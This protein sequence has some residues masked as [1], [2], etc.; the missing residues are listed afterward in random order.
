MRLA[1]LDYPGSLRLSLEGIREILTLANREA[2]QPLFEVQCFETHGRGWSSLA[3]FLGPEGSRML[4][5]GLGSSERVRILMDGELPKRIA[6]LHRQG[7]TVAGVCMGNFALGAAGLLDGREATTHWSLAE[8]FRG[9]FPQVKLRL[10]RIL[11]DHGDCIS[12]GGMTAFMDL[13]LHLIAREGGRGLA[14]RLARMLQ[15][16]PHRESQLPYLESNPLGGVPDPAL[17]RLM[18]ALEQAPTK[19]WTREDMAHL[20]AMAPRTLERRFR[21]HMGASPGQWLQDLRLS[22]ARKAL[23]EGASVAQACEATG[24]QDLSSFVRLF[25]QRMGSTPARYRAWV[26]GR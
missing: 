15:V 11:V 10:D 4:V 19:V 14:L 22:L 5:V 9:C 21:E 20:A 13:C 18:K 7:V 6:A 26:R 25:R 12:A 24:W 8:R 23:E 1:L 2:G 16:D 17:A 3:R